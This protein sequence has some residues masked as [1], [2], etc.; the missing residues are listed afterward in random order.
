MAQVT[1]TASDFFMPWFSEDAQ[2]RGTQFEHL[3]CYWLLVDPLRK[4]EYDLVTVVRYEDWHGRSGPDL[5]V[6]LVGTDSQ[7]RLWAVQCKAYA[8]DTTISKDEVSIL[9]GA[10][11]AAKFFG[12]IYITTSNS[13]T[14]NA[15][16]IAKDNS[17]LLISRSTLDS[18]TVSWPESAEDLHL[19]LGGE[20]V[21]KPK[22]SPRGHQQDAI[23]AVVDAF[24]SHDRAK[25]LMACGTGKT[26]TSLWIQEKVLGLGIAQQG[27]R[28]TVVLFPSISLLS[29][30]LHEWTSQ[31]SHTWRRLAVC[32]DQSVMSSRKNDTEDYSDVLVGDLDFS[33]TTDQS[34]IEEFLRS[35]DDQ[36]IFATYQS[37][38]Q[39]GQ[40][41]LNCGIEFDLVVCDEAHHLTGSLDKTNSSVLTDEK[42]PTK[43]RLFM[44]AT[45]RIISPLAVSE[46]TD[47]GYKVSSMDDEKLF[48]VISYELNFGKA[49][50]GDI[51][52]DYQVVIAVTSAQSAKALDVNKFIDINK[53]K[54]TTQDLAST[55]ASAKALE[56]YDLSRSI[57]FH[58]TIRRSKSFVHILKT[59]ST[60]SIDG[61]PTDLHADHVDGTMPS[62]ER[63][64]KLTTLKKGSSSHSLLANA[65]CL[66]EGVDVPALDGVIFVDPRQSEIDIVQAVGRAIRKSA[67]KKVGTVV[68]P[69]VCSVGSDG[70][71]Q[72]D[73]KGHKKLRQVLWSLRA[74]DAA[75]GVE[76]DE[77]VYSQNLSNH[78]VARLPSKIIIEIDAEYTGE[79]LRKFA[80]GISVT[81]LKAGSPDADWSERYNEVVE[82]YN[83]NNAWPS[84]IDSDPAVKALGKWVSHQRDSGKKL[85][86]G[87]KSEMTQERYDRLDKTPGWLWDSL[88]DVWE[89]NFAGC[90]E[91]YKKNNSWPSGED[92]DPA[93][94]RLGGW[95]GGQRTQGNKLASGVKSKMTQERYDRLDKTPGWLWDQKSDA[96]ESN[97][98]DCLEY[99][100]KNNSWPSTID[101]D[102]AVKPLGVW[103][104]NQRTQGNKLAS[105]V[106]SQMTQERYDR[107]DKTPGWLWDSLSDV[108]E[109]NFAG[110][111]E[112]YRK[113]NAWPSSKDSD[114]AV[115]PLG[116]W[117]FHQRDNGKKLASGATSPMTQ[118]RYAKLDKT[119][120]WLWDLF[121]DAWES[122]FAGCLEYYKKNNAWPSTKDSDAAVKPLGAWVGTQRVHGKKLASG[123]TS[124]MTQERYD[125]LDKTPGWVWDPFSD[126]W[127]SS[128]AGC[129]EYYRKN[130][131]WPSTKDS[132]AAVKPL[133]K[134]VG[135]QRDNGKKLTSGYKS[136]MTQE[137]YDRLDKTPG[138]LWDQKSDVW[139]SNFAGCLEYYRKNN[140]WPSKIDFDAAVKRLGEWVGHQ[141]ANGKKLASGVKSHMT[142][143]R[144][145]RLDKTPG[146]LWDARAL[147]K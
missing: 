49:I 93:V 5:G 25:L 119:P 26:L 60:E 97:F 27:P 98:A 101:S 39:V 80:S 136:S 51:L 28:R 57:S 146:W 94:K 3:M 64:K 42:F 137:R 6:D 105:G 22:S 24:K 18:S 141:R 29:Q 132:D 21:V 107:L 99:Y 133:G 102:P 31:R 104:S 54:T 85:A 125:R 100:A 66:S 77:L 52:T 128:F 78:G 118:E 113:N 139:E 135:H 1:D 76:I 56:K 7:G 12:R 48:G 69:I 90:L 2:T 59:L 63:L 121:S 114:P 61:V 10:S 124:P 84:T 47:A 142:Q 46:A 112:Y 92:S 35:D 13:F 58:S 88:S 144:Y 127:E 19:L 130:N 123:A 140:S 145:D 71:G 108:W 16:S 40:A 81:V 129:L 67:D 73:A 117:V 65:R 4:D 79:E 36:V 131:S 15:K 23:D 122:N 86:S 106:K 45:P 138:W 89:S 72:L 37:S 14:D 50:A 32:S 68:I 91:Y 74:H 95:V 111:L 38:K 62:S 8:L 33:V 30:T 34:V 147:K 53:T 116:K 115:K 75:L 43:K 120:G 143:E 96:W 44:T 17:V 110:C 82:H 126:A 41:A 109:S 70:A 103:V 20:A 83:K 55:I 11:P 87:V 9:V 134:W